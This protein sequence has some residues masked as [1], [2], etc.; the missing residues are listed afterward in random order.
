MAF[1]FQARYAPHRFSLSNSLGH[2]VTAFVSARRRQ[3]EER[4]AAYLRGLPDHVIRKLGGS[5]ADMEKLRRCGEAHPPGLYGRVSA[6]SV[7][8]SVRK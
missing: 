8:R 3:A 7:L 6:V 1:T 2:L 5:P 4:V